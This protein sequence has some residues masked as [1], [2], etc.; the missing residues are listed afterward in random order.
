MTNPLNRRVNQPHSRT[1]EYTRMRRNALIAM[2]FC[3]S[4]LEFNDNFPDMK[5]KECKEKHKV[6]YNQ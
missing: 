3:P 2:G 5:C 6:R 4:C 1:A